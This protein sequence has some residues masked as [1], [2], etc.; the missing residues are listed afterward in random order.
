MAAA[1]A[2]YSKAW[3]AD[4]RPWRRNG[5]AGSRCVLLMH[6]IDRSSHCTTSSNRHIRPEWGISVRISAMLI[7]IQFAIAGA[8]H[9]PTAV[10]ADETVLLYSIPE[11]IKVEPV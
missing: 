8:Q 1:C 9:D 5:F 3:T 4:K 11:R 6:A 10:I 7:A 2:P